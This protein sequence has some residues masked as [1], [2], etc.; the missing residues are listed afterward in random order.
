MCGFLRIFLR[1]KIVVG[2]DSY[3]FECIL[4]YKTWQ[5]F[6]DILIKV[7][8][9]SLGDLSLDIPELYMYQAILV[10]FEWGGMSTIKMHVICFLNGLPPFDIDG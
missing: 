7:C 3:A 8:C 2:F 5:V 9:I 1:A 6:I 4:V 10:Y